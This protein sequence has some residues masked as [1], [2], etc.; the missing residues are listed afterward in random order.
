MSKELDKKKQNCIG[1][2]DNYYNHSSNSTTGYCW[3]LE[4]AIFIDRQE[5]P[6]SQ[7]PPHTQPFVSRLNCY[8]RP[9]YAYFKKQ[10]NS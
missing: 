2:R 10:T 4:D 5:V 9:G 8:H 1:C 7:H 6:M 3:S